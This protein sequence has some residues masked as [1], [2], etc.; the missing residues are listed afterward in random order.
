M[1]IVG[2]PNANEG[3]KLANNT[4]YPAIADDFKH[5]FETLKSL[6]CD[7][8]LGAHGDYYNLATKFPLLHK[9]GRNPFIDPAG[10]KAYVQN[11]EQAFLDKLKQQSALSR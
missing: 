4:K 3:Y 8:F 10:Y 9:G 1:V 2:S 5:T 6:P 7:V 11:R